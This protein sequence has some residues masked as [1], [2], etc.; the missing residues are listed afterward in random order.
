[1][2]LKNQAVAGNRK[3]LKLPFTKGSTGD[4][5]YKKSTEGNLFKINCITLEDIYHQHFFND[6]IDICKIDVEGAEH[7]IFFKIPKM[8]HS[9]NY[10]IME[11]HGGGTRALNLVDKIRNANFTLINEKDIQDDV[12]FF[13][14]ITIDG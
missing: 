13:K 2:I 4:S 14:N 1:M 12:Y 11:I 5:L 10:L 8:I 7:E 9:L 3:S 6:I